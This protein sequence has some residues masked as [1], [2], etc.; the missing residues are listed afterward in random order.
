MV[1]VG[2]VFL[3]HRLLKNSLF[4]RR[5]KKVQV[6]GAARSEVRGV[7]GTYVAA[8]RE[9]CNAADGYFSAACSILTPRTKHNKNTSV[10]KFQR[11]DCEGRCHVPSRG[12]PNT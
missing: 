8:P 11:A 9:C 4:A 12:G 1:T 7:L 2:T 3:L 10:P 5:L 6:Q